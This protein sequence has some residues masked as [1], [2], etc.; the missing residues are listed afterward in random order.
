MFRIFIFI[1]SIS[2]ITLF[3]HYICFQEKKRKERFV[4]TRDFKKLLTFT[5]FLNSQTVVS[6][7]L[8]YSMYSTIHFVGQTNRQL[9]FILLIVK[10]TFHQNLALLYKKH[11]KTKYLRIVKILLSRNN[12]KDAKI[13][14]NHYPASWMPPNSLD[15]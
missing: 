7:T 4:L 1:F 8:F 15:T 10:I 9:F 2:F 6:V 14:T 12:K 3:K 11:T 5:T 13:T